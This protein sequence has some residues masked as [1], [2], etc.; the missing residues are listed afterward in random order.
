MGLLGEYQGAL[1]QGVRVCQGDR[2]NAGLAQAEHGGWDHGD[3]ETGGHQVEHGGLAA[4][5]PGCGRDEAPL[6][7]EVGDPPGQAAP[8]PV[9]GGHEGLFP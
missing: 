7:A 2:G 9:H 3:A 6:Q 8:L 4:D 1:S 5:D